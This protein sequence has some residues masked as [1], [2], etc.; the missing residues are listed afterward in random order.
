[1]RLSS[2]S[3][4]SVLVCAADRLFY[5]CNRADG[6]PPEVGL[7]AM[8]PSCLLHFCLQVRKAGHTEAGFLSVP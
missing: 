8:L 2:V 4:T 5:V 1:M 3:A 7:R 6:L